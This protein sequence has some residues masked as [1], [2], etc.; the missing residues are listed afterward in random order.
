MC[1]I[2]LRRLAR[3]LLIAVMAFSAPLPVAMAADISVDNFG[4]GK[5]HFVALVGEIR[6]GDGDRFANL[7]SGLPSAIVGLASPGGNAWA[8]TQ[9]GEVIKGKEIYDCRT[10]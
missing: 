10:G 8:A 7:V 1:F 2:M 3:R 9:I 4:T 6:F 5:P